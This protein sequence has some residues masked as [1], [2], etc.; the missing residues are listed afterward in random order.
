MTTCRPSAG[1]VRCR[2]TSAR[3]VAASPRTR[4]SGIDRR[5][6]RNRG[7]RQSARI[8]E[9]IDVAAAPVERCRRIK[10]TN[11]SSR[12][13]VRHP[14]SPPVRRVAASTACGVPDRAG[15]S[16]NARRR[17]GPSASASTRCR[18]GR[19]VRTPDPVPRRPHRRCAGRAPVRSGAGSSSCP[20]FRY[21]TT[22][23][24]A[25]PDAPQPISFASSTA[26][27][28]PASARCSA[29]ESP[30]KPA[31][32]TATATC[33]PAFEPLRGRRRRRVADIDV[34]WAGRIGQWLVHAC[35]RC[36]RLPRCA[37]GG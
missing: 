14:A 11:R 16:A 33:L 9:R 18:A 15:R 13:S 24:K 22:W 31:P 1:A 27:S 23:P 12:R 2:S 7:A 3:R 34:G 35:E 4:V 10:A 26:T 29:V 30:V 5:A 21:G 6:G 8:G 36:G 20:G 32:M 17:S 25:R 37:T 28:M 19:S